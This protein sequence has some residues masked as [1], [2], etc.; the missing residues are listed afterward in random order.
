MSEFISLEL[1]KKITDSYEQNMGLYPHKKKEVDDF[2][3][4]LSEDD[5]KI[6]MRYTYAYMPVGDIVTYDPT[7]LYPFVRGAFQARRTIPYTAQIPEELFLAYVL[8]YRINNENL[9]EHREAFYGELLPL[10][11][12][13]SMKD[14][15]ISVNYWCYEKATYIPTDI[16]TVAPLTMLKRAEGRCGEESVL[17]VAALRSIGIPAR[18]CYVPRWAHCDD[19]HA[20]VELWADGQWYYIGACEPEAILNKGWFTAAASKSMLVAAR[21]FSDLIEEKGAQQLTPILELVNT[22]F[23]YGECKRI[24]VT[25]TE[26]GIPV[27]GIEVQFELVNTGELY[28]IYTRLTD[29]S[30][31]VEFYTG[32]GDIYLHVHD[33][34]RFVFYKMDV[35]TQEQITLELE[36]AVTTDRFASVH[37]ESFDMAPPK[38]RVAISSGIDAKMDRI[39]KQLL[40]ECEKI[41]ASYKESF[42]SCEETDKGQ[43]SWYLMLARGNHQELAKFFELSQFTAEDQLQLLSTLLEKDFA[44]LSAE[45]LAEYLETSLQYKD[46][47]PEDIYKNYVLAPRVANE[48]LRGER[49]WLQNYYRDQNLDHPMKLWQYM[50]EH[51]KIVDE[52]GCDTILCSA[53]GSLKNGVCGKRSF[54]I[55]YVSICRAL[56]M[57]ARLNPVNHEPE[58]Y[59][60]HGGEAFDFIPVRTEQE[61]VTRYNITMKNRTGRNLNYEEHLTLAQFKQGRYETL[62]YPQVIVRDSWSFALEEGSYRILTSIRQINGMVSS[63]AYYFNVPE[64]TE[65]SVEVREDNTRNLLK[66]V[67]LSD[68]QVEDADHNKISLKNTYREDSTVLIFAEP[69]KEP[70][71]HLLQE[72]LGCKEELNA[73]GTR[74]C[75]VLSAWEDQENQTLQRVCREI[76]EVALYVCT[77][78]NYMVKLHEEMNVGDERLPFAIAVAPGFLGQYAFAN[79]N[80]G[81]AHTLLSILKTGNR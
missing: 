54:A 8:F 12:N 26:Q 10:I 17:A 65:L 33:D 4:D 7:E 59:E 6:G 55:V 1:S 29:H 34:N 36:N 75:I 5:E 68:E 35:R 56:G 19:N 39:H 52:L 31:K 30:G 81:T 9:D 49:R 60:V 45:L 79:Y 77:N 18:Q 58:Y 25:V 24:E 62:S 38:E 53:A 50:K 27:Q 28:P 20:W 69:G 66:Q 44:D 21:T 32:L 46:N 40:K 37:R 70:T 42:Y 80:I 23:T 64:V 15:A 73:S 78:Q 11:Q 2:I 3:K 48:M 47:Y 71:E 22:T 41:R 74:L 67:S 16:R 43:K 51:V 61:P 63:Y 76:S 13:K 72:L 14:A 57:A